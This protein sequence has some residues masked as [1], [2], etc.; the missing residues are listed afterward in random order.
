M[1]LSKSRSTCIR[2]SILLE[3]TLSTDRIRTFMSCVGKSEAHFPQL[4]VSGRD[5]LLFTL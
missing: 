5:A 4:L 2:S 3:P 1:E